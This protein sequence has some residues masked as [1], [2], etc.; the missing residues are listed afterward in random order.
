M[1]MG[2][3]GMESNDDYSGTGFAYDFLLGTSYRLSDNW[4]LKPTIDITQRLLIIMTMLK[5]IYGYYQ[6]LDL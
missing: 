4:S 5:A 1:G 6:R 2:I 3:V